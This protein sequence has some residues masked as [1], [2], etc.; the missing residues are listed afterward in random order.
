MLWL[1][2]DG[3]L[4]GESVG[5]KLLHSGFLAAAS[6]TA[7]F[8]AVPT[9]EMSDAGHFTMLAFMFIGGASGS[10]AGG[11][12]VGTFAILVAAAL[13]TAAGREN[14]EA[15]GREIR[16]ADVDRALTVAL[17]SVM[18]VFVLTLILAQTEA[19]E[20][21]DIMFE[22]TSAFGTTGLSTGIT[23]EM[24]DLSLL[25]LTLGMLVGRLGPL[26][27]A[28]ALVQRQRPSQRRLA[29]ERVRIG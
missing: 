22:A 7:G 3:V 23:S 27:L 1:E 2:W 8:S 26:T 21:L 6:R 14:V 28:L 13:S 17:G 9:S 12:K 5:G 19:L 20:F 11:I 24:S 16:R 4:G 25:L 29:E 18:F 15:G 10:T